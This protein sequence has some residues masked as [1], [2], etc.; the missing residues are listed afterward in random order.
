MRIAPVV[1]TVAFMAPAA[2]MVRRACAHAS[3]QAAQKRSRRLVK[4][5]GVE[6]GMLDEFSHDLLAV[7]SI[8]AWEMNKKIALAMARIN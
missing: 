8:K 4:G 5:P 6:V 1:H 2:S 7:S 3:P